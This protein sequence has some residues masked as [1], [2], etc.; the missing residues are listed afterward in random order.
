MCS[1]QSARAMEAL[2][3]LP[4]FQ[5]MPW[6]VLGPRQRTTTGLRPTYRTPTRLIPSVSMGM[7]YQGVFLP[8]QCPVELWDKGTLNTWGWQGHQHAT[9][10][11]R[12]AGMWLQCVRSAVWAT[13]SKAVG[14]GLSGVLQAAPGCLQSQTWSQRRLFFAAS[15]LNA[16]CLDYM[17]TLCIFTIFFEL[18]DFSKLA[19]TLTC[20]IRRENI[21]ENEC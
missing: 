3:P 5:R 19:G 13:L 10:A 17:V 7:G 4:R 15:I 14:E 1:W 12:V 16:V 9:S 8:G 21:L 18:I 2:L 20:V 6:W 11:R